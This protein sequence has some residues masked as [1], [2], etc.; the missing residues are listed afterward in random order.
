MAL[1]GGRLQVLEPT[2]SM[3]EHEETKDQSAGES[4]VLRD[5]RGKAER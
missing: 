1:G 5:M 3:Q 2:G 4:E